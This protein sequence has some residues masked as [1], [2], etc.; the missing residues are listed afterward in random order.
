MLKS[1]RREALV[2]I[3]AG[4]SATSLPAQGIYEPQALSSEDYDLLGTLV[5][6]ILPATDT[7]GARDV[8][9]HTMIDE[10]LTESSETLQIVRNG[11]GELREAGFARMT[12]QQRVA[13]L[14]AISESEG[15]DREFFDTVKG[16][17]IDLYYSTEVGLVQELGYQGNTYLAEFPGCTDEH[18]LGDAD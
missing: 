10:D 9:V 6:M 4:L 3:A 16:L 15:R 13:K 2:T 18:S 8:G 12:P 17:T 1:T 5:D 11:L 14:T 7:P